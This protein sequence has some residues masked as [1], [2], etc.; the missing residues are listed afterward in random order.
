MTR[1]EREKKVVSTLVEL[2]CRKK[3]GNESL[4]PRCAALLEYAYKRL[5]ACK[6]GEQK[7]SC[8]KCPVH[9]YKPEMRQQMR[10]VMRWV[11]PRMILYRPIAA[12]QHMIDE[13]F[14]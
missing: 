13:A 8:R 12:I 6:F 5:D 3:E 14:R 11:G 10:D 9:C 1:I 7:S 2:Y 4:C